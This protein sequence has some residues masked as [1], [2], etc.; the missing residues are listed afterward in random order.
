[1][2]SS[3]PNDD[4]QKA[5]IQSYPRLFGDG[6]YPE[7]G[8]GWCDTLE[9]LLARL[10]TVVAFEGAG[11][12]IQIVQIKEKFGTLRVYFHHSEG[13]SAAGLAVA[14]EMSALAEARSACTCEECGAIGRLHSRGGWMAT[15]CEE[16]A[17]GDPI[18]IAAGWKGLRV[19]T[20]LRDG[21][22]VTSC[23]RY[24]R[25]IDDF[26]DAPLPP[27]FENGE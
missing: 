7:V 2:N 23:R 21:L 20:S 6:G 22:L 17:D 8:R 19:T 14:S 13:F 25:D 12:W 26:E 4:W 11:A 10:D 5:L 15:R 16:H 9:R 27:D 24:D 3:A 1:M 18:P